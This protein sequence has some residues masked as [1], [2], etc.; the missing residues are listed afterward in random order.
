MRHVSCSR[1]VQWCAGLKKLIPVTNRVGVSLSDQKKGDS[2]C[3]LL[4]ELSRESW[5]GLAVDWGGGGHTGGREQEVNSL[6]LR[7]E[8]W[9]E[10][11]RMHLQEAVHLEWTRKRDHV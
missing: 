6:E 11:A 8:G 10:Y 3:L 9:G 7:G 5:Q 2:M 1:G 4:R